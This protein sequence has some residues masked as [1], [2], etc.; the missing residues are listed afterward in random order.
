MDTQTLTPAQQAEAFREELR[1]QL[2]AIEERL[3]DLT[4]LTHENRIETT[5]V[6]A[7]LETI[8]EGLT[9][10]SQPA[11]NTATQTFGEMIIESIVMTYNDSGAPIYKAK[12]APF[13]K[14]GVK[15]WD[16]VLPILG[17]DP[18]ALHPGTNPTSPIKARVLMGKT[19][20]RTTGEEGIGAIKIT[21]KA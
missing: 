9:H 6:R 21:G 14:Y 4:E 11:P 10:A 2:S 16:E 3:G 18:L 12:G 1:R 7:D 15:I 5:N 13:L 20:N 17:I 8:R 19:T